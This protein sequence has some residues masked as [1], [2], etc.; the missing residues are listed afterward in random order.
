ME[1]PLA[2]WKQPDV[3]PPAWWGLYLARLQPTL[4]NTISDLQ[5]KGFKAHPQLDP[6]CP[7]GL[8]MWSNETEYAIVVRT[9]LIF[10]VSFFSKNSPVE[11]K[12][13]T[14]VQSSLF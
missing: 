2:R 6:A 1:K 8:G 3:T 14:P 4:A 11:D 9:K 7:F 10:H 12:K 13:P 5:K